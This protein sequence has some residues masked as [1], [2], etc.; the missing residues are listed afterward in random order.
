MTMR[1]A[2]RAFCVR[3]CACMSEHKSESES[4]R[5]F[6]SYKLC[7]T[8]VRRDRSRRRFFRSACRHPKREKATA[9]RR[10]PLSSLERVV[11]PSTRFEKMH[12]APLRRATAPTSRLPS[13]SPSPSPSSPSPSPSS[14]SA[15]SSLPTLWTPKKHAQNRA[16]DETTACARARALSPT[17]RVKASHRLERSA[18]QR[19]ARVFKN[20]IG[21][22]EASARMRTLPPPSPTHL[23][24]EIANSSR[25]IERRLFLCAFGQK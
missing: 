1:V 8:L 3:V 7:R 24:D 4:E 9:P 10:K 11:T 15:S 16:A 17:N 20:G 14:P 21:R 18:S 6:H 13:P 22:H 19:S 5:A 23:C 12:F 25:F 2:S